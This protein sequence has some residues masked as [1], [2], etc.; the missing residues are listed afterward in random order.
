MSLA[1]LRLDSLGALVA[2]P[3]E[4]VKAGDRFKP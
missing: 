3:Q 4:K 2:Y 1:A